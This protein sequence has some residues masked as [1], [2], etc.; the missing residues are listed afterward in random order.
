[1]KS[2][3]IKLNQYYLKHGFTETF[4]RIVEWTLIKI[5]VPIRRKINE[6]LM[7][8]TVLCGDH[9]N[10]RDIDK[11]AP[12]TLQ[13]VI[14]NFG[15]GS[16]GHLNIFRFINLLSAQ[17]FKSHI[18]IV[19]EHNW[20]SSISALEAIEKWYGPI[21]A[22]LDFGLSGFVQS[23]ITLA[24]GWQT[25]YS[26]SNYLATRKKFYFIQ[27]FEP[28]FFPMSSHYFLAENSYRL[29]LRGITAGIWLKEKLEKEYSM[30]T[31]A[32]SFS[33]DRDLY[34]PRAK[35]RSEKFKILFYSRHVTPRRLFSLGVYSLSQFCKKYDDVEVIFVGGDVKQFDIN[36]DYIDLGQQPL[37]KLAEI[38]SQADLA[39]VLSATNL[40]LLPLEIAACKCPLVLNNLPSSNW[41]FPE[42]AVF[43]S[44]TDP[45][46]LT[47][48]IEFAYLNPSLREAKANKSLELARTSSWEVEADKFASF[49]K[50]EL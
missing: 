21:N 43:Y 30:K 29:D 4:F 5:N 18:V 27:D 34:F 1:M 12:K 44:S 36:F 46:A 35:I 40:S 13:W 32:I 47:E 31:N 50:A 10:P 45:R 17:G 24:T 8:D 23:E 3:L 22:T 7:I 25:A 28:F 33:Y 26:V 2:H 48:T 15:S 16:G 19:G 14:P 9:G 37:E 49:L 41:L 38:Y 42:E 20:N 11:I 6:N 39:L